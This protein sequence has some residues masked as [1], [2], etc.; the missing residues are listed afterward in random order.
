MTRTAPLHTV[1]ALRDGV[2]KNTTQALTTAHRTS[3]KTELYEGFTRSYQPKDDDGD[4]LPS[5]TKNVQLNADTVLNSM[6]DA[7]ARYWNLTATLDAGNQSARADVRI[8]TTVTG[9][10]GTPVYRTV[11]RDVPATF[12]LYLARELDDIYTF[13]AKLPTLDPAQRWTYDPNVAAFV[14]EPVE[15]H[16][17]VKVMQNHVKAEATDKFPAQ[18]DTFTA[19][20]VAGFWTLVKRSGALP[21]ERKLRLLQRITEL[22]LAVREARERA[23]EVQVTDVEVARPIFDYILGDDGA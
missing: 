3:Q 12:L 17:T 18:V 22:K 15:T 20:V 19:D 11:L 21:V 1:I 9:T 14:T 4:R 7:V 10:D 8:P 23:N 6:V 13:V 5:E 16:R 2:K